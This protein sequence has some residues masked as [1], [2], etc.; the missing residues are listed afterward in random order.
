MK[1]REPHLGQSLCRRGEKRLGR[2]EIQGMGKNG[3]DYFWTGDVITSKI[4]SSKVAVISCQMS[5]I[6]TF[7]NLHFPKF[8][9]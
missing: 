6:P 1:V 5:G 3:C 4:A 8:R 7:Q 2:G 9:G